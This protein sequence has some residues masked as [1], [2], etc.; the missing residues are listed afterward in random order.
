MVT[1]KGRIELNRLLKAKDE[2]EREIARHEREKLKIGLDV[3]AFW[4]SIVSL[5]VAGMALF[6]SALNRWYVR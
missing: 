5:I 2:A 4:L 1:S 6:I 3:K